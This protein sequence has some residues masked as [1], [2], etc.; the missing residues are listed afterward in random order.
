MSQSNVQHSHC[1]QRLTNSDGKIIIL[2]G[3]IFFTSIFRW[4]CSTGNFPED[5]S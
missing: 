2:P 3:N 5:Q 4:R 1:E